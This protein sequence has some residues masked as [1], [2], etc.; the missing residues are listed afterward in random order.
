MNFY[1]KDGKLFPMDIVPQK[2]LVSSE[3]DLPNAD[4]FAPGT[5]AYT[6]GMGTKWYVTPAGEWQE[7]AGG[8]GGSGGDSG[9]LKIGIDPLTETMDKTWQEIYD[10]VEAGKYCF[11]VWPRDIGYG[12]FQVLFVG[13]QEGEYFVVLDY[14]GE[15]EEYRT[16]SA[17]GYPVYADPNNNDSPFLPMQ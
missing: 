15:Q 7:S 16:N 5:I 6:V 1:V 3:D 4:G 12:I 17:N 14:S 11:A 8:G 10:A 13:S 9:V 2:I